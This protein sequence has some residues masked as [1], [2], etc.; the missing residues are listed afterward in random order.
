MKTDQGI[1]AGR[2][3]PV[4]LANLTIIAIGAFDGLAIVAA[5]PS[6]TKDLGDVGLVPWVITAYLAT[7]AVAVIVVIA[8][9]L[10]R[11]GLVKNSFLS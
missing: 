3:L 2:Y 5:L 10:Q 8:I 11:P 7:S 6:I 1:W 9:K 4:T